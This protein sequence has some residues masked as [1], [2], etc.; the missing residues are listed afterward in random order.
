VVLLTNLLRSVVKRGATEQKPT[1]VELGQVFDQY[2]TRH[3][4][5]AQAVFDMSR[6][7]TRMQAWDTRMMKFLSLYV[8][9]YLDERSMPNDLGKIVRAGV[10]LDCRPV[11]EWPKG[12]MEWQYGS[13]LSAKAQES[14]KKQSGVLTA[15]VR[16]VVGVA[17]AIPLF[18]WA[19]S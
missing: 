2:Q 11:P 19:T 1:T 6:A 16:L 18:V 14:K 13:A 7:V 8:V 15:A 17:V 12:A 3:L 4:P 5:R 10:L 9:P